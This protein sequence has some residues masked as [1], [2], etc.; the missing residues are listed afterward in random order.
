MQHC[1]FISVA[2]KINKL[3]MEDQKLKVG[4]SLEFD[5]PISGEPPPEVFWTLDGNLI[6]IR[7]NNLF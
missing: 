2:P 1:K 7:Y 4:Q 3:A 5:V 6:L